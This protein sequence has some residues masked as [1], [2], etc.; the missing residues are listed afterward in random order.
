MKS[1][2]LEPVEDGLL[3]S[4]ARDWTKEKHFYLKRYMEIFE[5]ALKEKFHIRYYLD[6]CSGPGKNQ[7]ED[8]GDIILG[9][10]LI[11]LTLKNPFT[12]YVFFEIND[13]NVLALRTRTQY[14]SLSNSVQII[15]GDVN[16]KISS[17]VQTIPLN[18]LNLAFIDPFSTDIYWNTIESLASVEKMDLIIYYPELTFSR[19]LKNLSEIPDITKFDLFFGS[20]KWRMIY[21]KWVDNNCQGSV[22]LELIKHYRENL[23]KLGYFHIPVKNITDPLITNTRGGH[24]YRLLLESKHPLGKKFWKEATSKDLYGQKKLP[25]LDV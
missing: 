11:A 9:S 2:Y 1:N 21:K 5:G 3:T 19:N 14:S 10:P 16:K 24:L 23:E 6:L 25:L 22:Q 12:N 7:L 18:S 20:E 15:Q 4:R 17:V 8:N 13:E